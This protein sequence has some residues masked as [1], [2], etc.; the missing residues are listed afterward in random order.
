MTHLLTERQKEVYDYIC[1]QIQEKGIGPSV[2]EIGVNLNIKSPNGVMCHLR[3]LERKGMIVRIA[4]KTRAIELKKPSAD[5]VGA[6]KAMSLEIRGHI[7]HRTCKWTEVPES[8]NLAEHFSGPNRFLMVYRG[9]GLLDWSI[10]DGDLLVIDQQ[11][12]LVHNHLALVKISDELHEIHPGNALPIDSP[13]PSV[14]HEAD[15][16]MASNRIGTEESASSSNV[17][18]GIVGVVIGVLRKPSLSLQHHS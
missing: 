6:D 3:A 10:C 2:R 9:E 8:I 18:K 1:K 5:S 17:D 13:A 16:A 7:R 14:E 11:H 15:S 12:R 4:N